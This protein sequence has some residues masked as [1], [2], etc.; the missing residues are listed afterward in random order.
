ME[1]MR[2]VWRAVASHDP[3]TAL[4]E[5]HDAGAPRG[6]RRKTMLC[7]LL[8]CG[9][10]YNSNG[11]IMDSG[12]TYPARLIPFSIL[13]DGTTTLD[14]YFAGE[15]G[16]A[17][18]LRRAPREKRMQYYYL[19][20]R[21]GRLHSSY[22]ITTPALITPLYAPVVWLRGEWTTADVHRIA[23]IGEKLTASLIA[24]LSVACMYLL[25]AA[26]TTHRRALVLALA[27]GLATTTW[28]T[29]SQ[30]LWQHGTGVLFIVL[31]LALLAYRPNATYLTG[32]AAGLAVDCRPSN[33]FFLLAVMG[34]V[35]YTR[36]SLR[37]AAQLAL[38]AAVVGLPLAA[39]NWVVFRDLRGGYGGVDD[40]F[41]GS[42]A[43]GL[44]GILVSPS[45]GLF[46]YSPVVLA[47]FYGLWLACRR[48]A[49]PRSPVYAV[50]A[51]FLATQLVFF[52]WWDTWWGGWSYGPR[53]LTEAAAVLVVLTVPALERLHASR[54]ARSAFA[55][56]LAY[57]VG[58]QAIGAFAYTEE[59]D[60]IPV[61][62][63][64]DPARLWDW[65]DAQIP[66]TVRSLVAGE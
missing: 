65:R 3:S 57:S 17:E 6:R 44:L 52:G 20:P 13:L 18:E 32:V 63:D 64:R 54:V 26:L 9:F 49:A 27:F 33:L 37:S 36:G 66:R 5:A 2:R 22:P 34:V 55:V 15:V 39:Y 10:V 62:V 29:S 50:A 30:A 48:T 53:L 40:A 8:L 41:G 4:R 11:K 28:T 24:S 16:S 31:T 14:R 7:L 42:L 43:E 45:R 46:I 21:D 19:Q 61:S 1:R 12:D 38:G 59:W 51:I 25:L 23:P 58:V 56:L 60:A 47:G 35:G